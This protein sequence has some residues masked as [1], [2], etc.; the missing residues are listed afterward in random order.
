MFK[1]FWHKLAT[2]VT[3]GAVLIA[4]FSIVSKLLGFLRDRLLASYFG[5]GDVLDSYYA[6]F[7]LPDLIF[8]TLVLGA[9]ASAFIPVFT[10]LWQLEKE[11]AL[12]LASTV[13]NY[14]VIVLIFSGLIIFT[15]APSIVKIITPGFSGEKLELTVSLTRI[16]LFSIIFFGISNVIGGILNSFKRFFSFSLAPVFYNLGIIFGIAVLYKTWGTNGLAWGVVSGSLLHLIVQLP[17]VF[18]TG[19]RYQF[20]FKI[21]AE[22]KKVFTLMIPRTIGLAGNQLN[23]LIITMIASML[24]AGSI[25]IYNLAN[26]LQS[27]PS[28]VFGVSLAI[29]AFPVFS[30]ALGSGNHE[31]FKSVFSFHFRRILFLII[32]L[33]VFI[34]LLR[35]QIVRVILGAGNFDWADTYYTAQTL[36]WFVISLF[37]Q[38]LIP[39]LARSFYALEDTRTPVIVSLI[40]IVLNIVG[41]YFLGSK[42]GVEGLALAFSVASIL[43]MIALMMILRLRLGYLDDK[44]IIWSTFKI[45]LN[46]LIA[47]AGA[48]FM[49]RVMADLVNMR[50][51]GGI[52]LQGLTSGAVGIIIYLII[53]LF[54]NCEEIIIVKKFLQRYLRPLFKSKS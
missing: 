8:N 40:T 28:S 21:T 31:F 20:T 16:M 22:V 52:L 34:L 38:S 19:W 13:L 14:L 36:G 49:L 44:K 53:S 42:Y 37:A 11:K 35:A 1:I 32:P 50:T 2:T 5:A 43:N 18:K 25:A 17:E 46:S 51:F 29:A 7:R 41:S 45:S 6:A 3:G 33:S 54:T 4:I 47:G 10:K 48:Y 23:Q 9:L 39:L 27:F 26:N 15:F 24:A 30:E 12:K